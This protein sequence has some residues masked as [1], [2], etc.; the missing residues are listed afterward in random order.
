M[1]MMVLTN[2]R[3]EIAAQERAKGKSDAEAYRIAYPKC[4]EASAQT[5]G[6]RLFRTVQ[7]KNRVAELQAETAKAAVVTAEGIIDELEEARA[8]ARKLGQ[9]GAMV[10]ASHRKAMIAGLITKPQD[11]RNEP[12]P[13][14]KELSDAELLAL[15]QACHDAA[16]PQMLDRPLTL[17]EW[18]AL[19]GKPLIA[20]LIDAPP[21]VQS[22]SLPLPTSRTISRSDR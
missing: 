17:E 3:H 8:L 21:R 9:P 11:R 14:L 22:R 16:A 7:V 12:C 2:A 1:N 20:G 13:N 4:S 15:I 10:M 19:D 6:P 5:A 18:E